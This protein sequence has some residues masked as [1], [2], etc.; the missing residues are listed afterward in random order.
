MARTEGPLRDA[1][2][3]FG[4][5]PAPERPARRAA[6]DPATATGATAAP[7]VPAA[8]AP[9]PS[10][11]AARP[12]AKKAAKKAVKKAAKKAS[13]ARA[14]AT[15]ASASDLPITDYD[16]LSASQVVNRLQGLATGDLDAVRAYEA[17]TRARKTILNRITQ[18]Q[19]G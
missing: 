12:A 1:L 17:A 5:V 13:T 15:V 10:P 16:S 4:V 7:P 6:A 11:A 19:K 3:T 18:I 9:A 14:G 8:D 2:V